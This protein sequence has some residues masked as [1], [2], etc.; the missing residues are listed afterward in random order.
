MDTFSLSFSHIMTPSA[1]DDWSD[2]NDDFPSAAE[3]SVLLGIPDGLI[4]APSDICDAAVSR[5]GGHPAFL[6]SHEPPITS[7]Y[8]IVCENPM[9]LLVQVWC[10]FED[11]PMDRALH[12]W[13]CSRVSCRKKQGSIRAWRGVRYNEKYAAKLKKK[14]Q[15]KHEAGASSKLETLKTNPFSAT[16]TLDIPSFGL[17]TQIFGSKNVEEERGVMNHEDE[18]ESDASEESLLTAMT[19]AT[20][21]ESPWRSAPAYTPIYLSTV[22]EYLPP[23]P[24]LKAPS[25]A[26][27]I[28][29]SADMKGESFWMSERYEQSLGLDPV[30]ER[31]ARRVAA[32]GEQCIRYELNGIPLPFASDDVYNKLFPK[33]LKESLSVTKPDFAVVQTDRRIFDLSVVPRCAAC[34]SKRAFE[35]Q[36]MPNLINVVRTKETKTQKMTD[37][38]RRKEVEETLCGKGGMEW[39]TCLVFSC[40]EDCCM[41]TEAWMEEIVYVQWDA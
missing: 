32:E 13:G 1:R 12:I 4:D 33:P 37:E 9:E 10:P 7:S 27:V 8:C 11:S 34:K 18:D 39:G 26:Q 35:C 41:G 14:R 6:L 2:S 5:I 19:K 17:G 22:S 20:I 15:P 31:F 40:S 25:D 29:S 30:F 21:A 23:E 36:L 3:T 24:K 38:E 28:D 16:G